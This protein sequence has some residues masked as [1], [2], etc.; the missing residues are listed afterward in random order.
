MKSSH[1]SSDATKDDQGQQQHQDEEQSSPTSVQLVAESCPADPDTFFRS[2]SWTA[3]GV[4]LVALDSASILSTHVLPSD[5]LTAYSPKSGEVHRP[6]TL[7][8]S[9]R[10]RLPEPC[11]AYVTAPYFSVSAPE[12]QTVLVSY[13]DHPIHLR[14]LLPRGIENVED[15]ELEAGQLENKVQWP[16]ALDGAALCT[17]KLINARTEAYL[18][19]SSLLWPGMGSHFLAGSTNRIDLFD[20]YRFGGDGPMLSVPTIPSKRHVSKGGGVGMKG[21][22]SSLSLA[23]SGIGARLEFGAGPV[24]AGTWTR[25]IGLYD[26]TRTPYAVGH[27][28]VA[29]VLE[30]E[31]PGSHE[32][33]D[34]PLDAVGGGA[35]VSQT[36][37]SPCGRYLVVN[38][39]G[40]EALLVYDVRG[41]RR[42]V[43]AL[44][45]RTTGDSLMR[46]GCDV[47]PGTGANS[48]GFEVWAGCVDGT[49][50]VWEGVGTRYGRVEGWRW[51]ERD[52]RKVSDSVALT[53]GCAPVGSA[54]LHSCGSV[55]ATCSGGWERDFEGDGVGKRTVGRSK[56]GIWT[57]GGVSVDE[58]GPVDSEGRSLDDPLAD[59]S[60]VERSSLDGPFG[61]ESI[62][63]ARLAEEQLVQDQLAAEKVLDDGAEIHDMVN[64]DTADRSR[65]EHDNG[66]TGIQ[67]RASV[68]V[69][70]RLEDDGV[71]P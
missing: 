34:E 68:Q 14:Q 3:D 11:A 12:T 20:A 60:L 17:Y 26:L 69:Q 67:E 49:V 64:H 48:N 22:V 21:I 38:E 42:P 53:G 51:D 28:T 50:M 29:G 4:A 40:A 25:W 7:V 45:G 36:I 44:M 23:P 54:V 55:L 8:P 5:L 63:Q 52:G 57:V 1:H 46:F 2:V 27:W 62:L 41:T 71:E 70:L 37:W 33:G 47:Y 43:S 15:D 65:V 30:A 66:A 59:E 13:R 39:R 6:R 24:A 9:A 58:A 18:T 16:E 19:P 56:L 32:D 35:G 10:I 61:E 31:F